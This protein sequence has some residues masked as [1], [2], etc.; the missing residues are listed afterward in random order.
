M[1]RKI[2]AEMLALER[3]ARLKSWFEHHA[4]APEPGVVA[5]GAPYQMD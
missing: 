4:N 1:L 2:E 3:I 5:A